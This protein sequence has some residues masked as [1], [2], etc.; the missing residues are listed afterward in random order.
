MNGSPLLYLPEGGQRKVQRQ[1]IEALHV[2]MHFYMS[3]FVQNPDRLP[4]LHTISDPRLPSFVFTTYSL[5]CLTMCFI[6]WYHDL[7]SQKSILDVDIQ[8]SGCPRCQLPYVRSF[9]CW[10]LGL[11]CGAKEAQRASVQCLDTVQSQTLAAR[12]VDLKYLV[13]YLTFL[14]YL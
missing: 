11:S 8:T 3:V 14:L 2:A 6:H 13:E 12:I 1:Y 7:I 9:A 4:Y 10:Y 5:L